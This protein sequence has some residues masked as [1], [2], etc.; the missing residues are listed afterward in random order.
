LRNVTIRCRFGNTGVQQVAHPAVPER[1]HHLVLFARKRQRK[2]S[3]A[4][5]AY[6]DTLNNGR[7]DICGSAAYCRNPLRALWR[8]EFAKPVVRDPTI[9]LP[10]TGKTVGLTFVGVWQ[11]L[12]TSRLTNN[13]PNAPA[14]A[15]H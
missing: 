3:I 8:S 9:E 4:D 11:K 12:I 1:V 10:F 15:K 6:M 2:M 13:K 7:Q 14:L 5:L